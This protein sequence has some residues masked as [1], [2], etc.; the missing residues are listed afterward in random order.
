LSAGH[1]QCRGQ[2]TS[3]TGLSITEGQRKVYPELCRRNMKLLV[4]FI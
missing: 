2:A 4:Y 3:P 1:S